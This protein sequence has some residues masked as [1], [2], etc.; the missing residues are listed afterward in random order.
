MRFL[1]KLLRWLRVPFL[2]VLRKLR[3]L[4]PSNASPPYLPETYVVA[5][6][7]A[8]GSAPHTLALSTTNDIKDSM[9]SFLEHA[10][11]LKSFWNDSMSSPMC[12][13][14]RVDVE[15]QPSKLLNGVYYFLYINVPEATFER[16]T[17]SNFP[18]ILHR[19]HPIFTSKDV[20]LVKTAPNMFRADG[21]ADLQDFPSAMLGHPAFKV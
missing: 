3:R 16:R 14:L 12:D 5:R 11:D 18:Q 21:L 13:T 7:P 1:R 15:N 10:P 6:Y 4:P 2:G 8:D 20:F 19:G 17:R 9:F